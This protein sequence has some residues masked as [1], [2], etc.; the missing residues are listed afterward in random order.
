MVRKTSRE[1]CGHLQSQFF[2]L[3]NLAI[4]WWCVFIFR[5]LRLHDQT[6]TT[7]QPR[8]AHPVRVQWWT[9][10]T[11]RDSRVYQNQPRNCQEKPSVVVVVAV[12]S[13]TSS[14]TFLCS[15]WWKWRKTYL[16]LHID[17]HSL[18][19][20]RRNRGRR[21][22]SLGSSFVDDSTVQWTPHPVPVAVVKR[23]STSSPSTDGRTDRKKTNCV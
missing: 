3:H 11:R 6:P 19:R 16:Y 23:T 2:V 8:L 14:T 13:K 21:R 1:N 5:F 20:H 22:R 17:I 10:P 7:Q 18:E 4:G 12:S 15:E 9:G